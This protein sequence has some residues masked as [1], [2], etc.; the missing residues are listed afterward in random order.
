MNLQMK[1]TRAVSQILGINTLMW[2]TMLV[3]LAGILFLATAACMAIAIVLPLAV[4]AL[5]TGVILLIVFGLLALLT[6]R[7][8]R[9]PANQ[10]TGKS[11]E[12]RTD[13]NTGHEPATGIGQ[14]TVDW[15]RNNPDIAIAGALATGIALSASSNLRHFAIRTAAPILVRNVFGTKQNSTERQK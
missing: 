11:A 1:A 13:D 5:V 4:A 8:I 9:T 15:A 6:R 7:V 14:H 10:G 12:S 3:L 2:L